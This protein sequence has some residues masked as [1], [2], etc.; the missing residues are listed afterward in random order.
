MRRVTL[1]ECIRM[2]PRGGS[3]SMGWFCFLSFVLFCLKCFYARYGSLFFSFFFQIWSLNEFMVMCSSLYWIVM[4]KM[5]KTVRRIS[6]H[7]LT[8]GIL[9]NEREIIMLCV[10]WT[11]LAATASAVTT[12][13]TTTVVP[14]L[15]INTTVRENKK[16][17][18]DRIWT[19][20]DDRNVCIG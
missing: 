17:I 6:G 20:R 4:V 9:S 15:Y 11:V 3:Y 14:T 8:N 19:K 1:Y 2:Q 18:C 12:T 10:H 5:L 13:T 7:G 16:L